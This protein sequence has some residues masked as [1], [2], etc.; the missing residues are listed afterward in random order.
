MS[1]KPGPRARVII[2]KWEDAQSSGQTPGSQIMCSKPLPAKALH[3][4]SSVRAGLVKRGPGSVRRVCIGS[5]AF[6][7]CKGAGAEASEKQTRRRQPFSSPAE[8]VVRLIGL[9]RAY[10][11]RYPA[12]VPEAKDAR[13]LRPRRNEDSSIDLSKRCDRPAWLAQLCV[14]ALAMLSGKEVEVEAESKSLALRR[15]RIRVALE[16]SLR[17]ALRGLPFSLDVH[18]EELELFV[19]VLLEFYS[20]LFE[21]A[22]PS[23]GSD[24]DMD[25]ELISKKSPKAKAK[26]KA[27]TRAIAKGKGVRKSEVGTKAKAVAKSRPKRKNPPESTSRK[28]PSEAP[29]TVGEHCTELVE[30][31]DKD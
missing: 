3:D 12:G 19:P 7:I 8:K 4:P 30:G 9:A 11:L 24:L 2:P 15:K 22:Q 20:E 29:D 27:E 1:P 25:K 23:S 13:S 16:A 18:E 10:G 17:C 14:A 31:I 26:A 21:A 6:F 5:V 28:L